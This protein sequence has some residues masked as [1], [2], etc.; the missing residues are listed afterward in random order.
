MY[1]SS[2]SGNSGCRVMVDSFG[3]Q[4]KRDLIFTGISAR[5][6]SGNGPLLRL[7]R[8]R[9]SRNCRISGETCRHPCGLCPL[10]GSRAFHRRRRCAGSWT[11]S[12]LLI[13]WNHWMQ[14]VYF[15]AFVHQP[16]GL[17]TIITHMSRNHLKDRFLTYMTIE[18]NELNFSGNARFTA[19]CRKWVWVSSSNG[20][21]ISAAHVSSCSPNV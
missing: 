15:W 4:E 17:R 20:R 5:D 11:H 13:L 14:V 19:R 10:H 7:R 21:I 9:S 8:I 6:R 3:A 2:S 18:K 1:R 16:Y 12:H